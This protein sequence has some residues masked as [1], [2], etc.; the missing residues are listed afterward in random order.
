MKAIRIHPDPSGGQAALH[1]EDVPD[2]VPGPRE[3]VIR[4]AAASVNR[5]DLM[6][7]DN[8]RRNADPAAPFTPGTDVAGTVAAVGDAVHE[9]RPGDLVV[10]LLSGGGYAEKV[11]THVAGTVPVPP[12]VDLKTAAGVPV[13]YLTVW[14]PLCFDPG[15]KAGETILVQSG[16]SGVGIAA[17][18]VA[19]HLGAR[20]FA[21][22][23]SDAKVERLRE[24]GV[25]LAINYTT[26]DFLPLVME[27]TGG[28]G[29][30]FVL[31]SVGGDVFTKSVSA[32]AP[33]GRLSIVGNSSG[34]PEVTPDERL[35]AERGLTVKRFGLPSE[36]PTGGTRRELPKVLDLVAQGVLQPVID[37]TF[38]LAEAEAAH[39]HL[40]DRRN[41]GKVLLI[42]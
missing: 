12:G 27:A 35:V 20:V 5:S 29:V 33:G 11:V 32:L 42:P 23:G 9:L 21:T 16:A 40:A 17:I 2:P 36:I 31:E 25:D 39:A 10:A 26:Q 14:F 34:A 6:R 7:R 15:V 13:V 8:Y 4:I 24:Q 38:P 18:Q 30:D 3:V 1:Y 37:R 19:K 22:A 28:R 41:F